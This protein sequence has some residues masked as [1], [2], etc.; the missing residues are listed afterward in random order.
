[1]S[2]NFLQIIIL[3][4]IFFAQI[5]F[6]LRQSEFLHTSV[7]TVVFFILELFGGNLRRRR[8][9]RSLVQPNP[10]SGATAMRARFITMILTLPLPL[11]STL[12]RLTSAKNIQS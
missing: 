10:Q 12:R 4:S 7:F 9:G 2:I 5:Y 8:R 11:V 3:L 1:M 6:T